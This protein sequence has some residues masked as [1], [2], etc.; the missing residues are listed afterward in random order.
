[1]AA[2]FVTCFSCRAVNNYFHA[3]FLG[4]QCD[5]DIYCIDTCVRKYPNAIFSVE[6]IVLHNF[7]SVSF[8]SFQEQELV[9]THLADD[10]C[11]ECQREFAQRVETDETTDT[12]IHFLNRDSGMATSERVYPTTGFD[13][14]CH[15]GGCLFDILQLRG[16]QF[17]HDAMR[18][19]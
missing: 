18:V 17:F 4:F 5:V 13:R 10:L 12:R 7:L 6:I 8:S 2:C 3:T 15:N 9:D 14:I 11:K 1:M 16:F 19:F